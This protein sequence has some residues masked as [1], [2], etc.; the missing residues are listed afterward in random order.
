MD[1]DDLAQAGWLERL[2]DPDLDADH[3]DFARV[4]PYRLS[5]LRSIAPRWNGALVRLAIGLERTQDLI[6]D[7]EQALA[8]LVTD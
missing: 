5:A 8:A 2:P 4:V 6:A 1:L 3:C 7:L